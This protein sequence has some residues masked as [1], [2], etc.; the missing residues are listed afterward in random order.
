MNNPLV[1]VIIATHNRED[2]LPQAVDSILNQTYQDFEVIIVDDCSSDN[3]PE[4]I[5]QLENKD[6]RIRSI[7]SEQNIGPGA[8][9]NLG[10]NKAKGEF[11]A[12]MDDDDLAEPER[13]KSEISAF[14]LDPEVML[15]FSSVAWVDDNL[16][17]I[18]TFPG[19]LVKNMFPSEPGEV[20]NLLYLES[21][22][23]PNATIMTKK[24]L[25]TKFRY[26]EIPWVGEDWYLFLQLAASGVKMH[27]ISSPLLQVRRGKAHQGLMD[28]PPTKVFK[29]QRRVLGMI[30]TWL[31][32]E[33]IHGFDHLHKL[34]LSNQILRE[35]RHFVGFKGLGMILQ[36]FSQSPFNP[37]VGKEISWYLNK[38]H[39]KISTTLKK[40]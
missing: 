20:F 31:A 15:V 27:A 25:W 3:S 4:V 10:I 26:I 2:L 32:Q 29:A 5:R 34:A 8:A 16:Q 22:K 13:L 1:S 12:I 38:L 28:G 33:G 6:P 30:K 14:E 19:L 24:S 23:I 35:S 21:N 39:N 36:A 9:R 37:K 17:V 7:R 18:N 11:I 40:S